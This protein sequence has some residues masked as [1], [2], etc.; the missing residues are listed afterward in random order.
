MNKKIYNY[1]L[2]NINEAF[3]LERYAEVRDSLNK[4]TIINELPWTS[5]RLEKFMPVSYTHLT[6]PTIY[7]V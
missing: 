6:L 7:S 3:K 1:L 4:D 5:K 2:K